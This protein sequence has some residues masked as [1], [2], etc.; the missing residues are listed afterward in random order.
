[1]IP[2]EDLTLVPEEHLIRALSA[3]HD[4]LIVVGVRHRGHLMTRVSVS[5]DA[6]GALLCAVGVVSLEL[7]VAVETRLAELMQSDPPTPTDEER[8]HGD[9]EP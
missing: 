5:A 1:M 6:A 3:R 8:P 4:A 2:L 7:P 9:R